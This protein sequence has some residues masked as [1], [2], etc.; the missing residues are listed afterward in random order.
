MY[1]KQGVNFRDYFYVPDVNELAGEPQHEREDHNQREQNCQ[2]FKERANRKRG[3]SS[4]YKSHEQW[5]ISFNYAA[6][7]GTKKQ[8]E[9][10]AEKLLSPAVAKRLKADNFLSEG[11]FVEVVSN[12]HKASDGRGLADDGRQNNN[13]D[14]LDYFWKTGSHG[15][16]M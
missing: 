13:L 2:K 5:K 9:G 1:C 11:R 4:I 3:S 10:D 7:T 12:W 15:T 14:M 16:R 8:S 6:L